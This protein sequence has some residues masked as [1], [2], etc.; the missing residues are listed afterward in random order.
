MK[1]IV[2]YVPRSLIILG[3]FIFLTLA[4]TNTARADHDAWSHNDRGYWDNHHAYHHFIYYHDHRGYWRE[5]DNGVRIW[6]N[7]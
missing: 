2:Q 1:T 4:A 5:N 6:V 7:I 3:S